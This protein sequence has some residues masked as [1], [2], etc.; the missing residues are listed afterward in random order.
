[1]D[2]SKQFNHLK[3]HTQYS[4]CEG[5]VKIE[6]L[7]EY[8]KKAKIKSIGISDT[9]NLC[10]ALEFSESIS[11]TKTQPIIGSQIN[12]KFKNFSGVIPIIAKN[13]KGYQNLINFSS[14]SYLQTDDKNFSNYLLNNIYFSNEDNI[15]FFWR[16]LEV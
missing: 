2:Q 3:L 1:M 13:K 8:C 11:K 10:G 7:S 12:F 15:I 16:V 14:N 6:N 4:I 9:A 5:A